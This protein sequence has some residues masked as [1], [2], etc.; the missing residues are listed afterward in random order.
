MGCSSGSNRRSVAPQQ[1][2]K[3]DRYKADP[4]KAMEKKS[5]SLS[6]RD[7]KAGFKKNENVEDYYRVMETLGRGV[8]N[9]S[10]L[11]V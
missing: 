3:N 7:I 11:T 2:N 9:S 1:V 10:R 4:R 8:S 6:M 5:N